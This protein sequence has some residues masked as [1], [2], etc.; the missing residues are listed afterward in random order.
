MELINSFCDLL[1]SLKIQELMDMQIKVRQLKM[2]FP[3][4]LVSFVERIIQRYIEI[5]SNGELA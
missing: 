5:R 4:E 3:E 1:S 2:D